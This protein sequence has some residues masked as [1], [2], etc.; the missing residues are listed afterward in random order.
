MKHFFSAKGKA[1]SRGAC[2][3]ETKAQWNNSPKTCGLR[4]THLAMLQFNLL[5]SCRCFLL[6]SR[7]P[8]PVCN[9]KPRSE[10]MSFSV[11]KTLQNLAVSVKKKKRKPDCRWAVY[12]QSGLNP[13][14]HAKLLSHSIFFWTVF[15]TSDP[16]CAR[17]VPYVL[18]CY[19]KCNVSTHGAADIFADWGSPQKTHSWP[20]PRV[21]LNTRA[22]IKAPIRIYYM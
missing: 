20:L 14:A 17:E 8:V 9:S 15:R 21:W 16:P 3:H 19:L 1:N 2:S 5:L 13:R 4:N 6:C 10:Q 22:T 18:V 7:V 11:H 12:I